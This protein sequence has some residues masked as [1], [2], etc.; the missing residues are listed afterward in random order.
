M[1]SSYQ[2]YFSIFDKKIIFIILIVFLSFFVRLIYLY[3]SD[4][5]TKSPIEDSADYHIRALN[6]ISEGEFYAFDQQGNKVFSSRPPLLSFLLSAAYLIPFENKILLGRFLQII[7]SSFTVFLSFVASRKFG[8]NLKVSFLIMFITCCYPPSIFYSSRI[9]TENLAAMLLLLSMIFLL[10]YF[11]KK[12]IF[13]LILAAFFLSLLTLSRS[14]YLLLPFFLI[15]ILLITGA[16]S[17][18]R[19]F[20]SHHISLF[21]IFSIIFLSP[22]TYRNYLIHEEIMPT[23]SR[24]G[25]MLYLS[26]NSLENPEILKGGYSKEGSLFKDENFLNYSE[27]KKNEIYTDAAFA[28]IISKPKLFLLAAYQRIENT[29]TWR[30]N[31]IARTAWVSSDYIMFIIWLPILIFFSLSIIY[32]SKVPILIS[33]IFLSYILGI[34]MFFWGIPRLRYPVDSIMI[35]SALSF[36]NFYYFDI[37]DKFFVNRNE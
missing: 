5:F 25:Y 26:N 12:N 23:T 27:S 1:I 36:I 15:F 10:D 17:K 28:E 7:I 22:W 33:W 34:S 9:L 11:S 14:S 35:I 29:L 18:R 3:L 37:K 13:H 4:G 31:P 2:K 20:K 24:L 19:L 8:L 6:L 30:P 21:I 16:I 32:L